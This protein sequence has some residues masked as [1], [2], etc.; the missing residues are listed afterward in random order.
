MYV[1]VFEFMHVSGSLV[2]KWVV[3][4]VAAC[5]RVEERLRQD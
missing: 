3:V 2:C 4:G 5:F 1:F